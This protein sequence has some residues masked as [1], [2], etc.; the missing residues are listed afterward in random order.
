MNIG[1]HRGNKNKI[2]LKI[3]ITLYHQQLQKQIKELK[4]Q[5]HKNNTNGSKTNEKTQDF[6]ME[7][8]RHI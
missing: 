8:S 3:E 6:H 7:N 5:Y 1:P 2:T 4:W